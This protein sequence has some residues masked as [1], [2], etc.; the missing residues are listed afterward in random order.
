M[1]LES[2]TMRSNWFGNDLSLPNFFILHRSQKMINLQQKYKDFFGGIC[3]AFCICKKF[4]PDLSDQAIALLTLQGWNEGF[5]DDDGY[6]SKPLEFIKLVSGKS[7]RDINKVPYSK[8]ELTEDKNIVMY[9]W[10][11]GTHFVI[12]D[13]N[14]DVIF[15]PSGFSNSVRYGIPV[16]IRKFVS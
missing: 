15:D 10:N 1:G 3:Y 4:R 8:E 2:P 12:L 7:F 11:G 14:A 6:I 13:Q 16:S 9:E 5:I